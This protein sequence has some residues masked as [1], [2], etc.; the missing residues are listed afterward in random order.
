MTRCSRLVARLCAVCVLFLAGS[1]RATSATYVV[2]G[3]ARDD[4]SGTMPWA[5][6]K[7]NSLN[8]KAF[9]FL[10]DMELSPLLDGHFRAEIKKLGTIPFY[11]IIGNHE[12]LAFGA[13][14]ER[15]KHHEHEFKEDF[16]GSPRTPVNTVFKDKVA[17]SV[18]LP[19]GLH[20]VAL[21]NV[22]LPGGGFGVEQLT[23]L[24]ADLKAARAN[25]AVKYIVVGMHKAL[26]KN[27]KTT[28]AMDEDGA[29]AI[30]ESDQALALLKKYKVDLILASHEHLYANFK[31]GG[32]DSHIT[33]GLGA[34]LSDKLGK[35]HAYHHALQLDVS[36]AG[37]KVTVLKK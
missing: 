19:G 31:Q 13:F 14:R 2:G 35:D 16:L 9:I 34:P 32:I 37:L 27:G 17:Y 25:K 10:G 23:W 26:A 22:S 3:D 6:A 15:T 20:L 7:A 29:H 33:G 12:V 21:D 36:D 4:W 5:I 8:A 1:A 11:P 28:H 24:E 30:G 18:D